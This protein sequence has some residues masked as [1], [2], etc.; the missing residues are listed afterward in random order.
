M[1]LRPKVGFAAAPD[2]PYE[3]R[4]ALRAGMQTLPGASPC[5][6]SVIVDMDVGDQV[7]VVENNDAYLDDATAPSTG[8]GAGGAHRGPGKEPVAGSVGKRAGPSAG[9]GGITQRGAVSKKAAQWSKK[10]QQR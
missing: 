4:G 1:L 2:L 9:A 10:L 8:A 6:S 7:E 3:W 5:P